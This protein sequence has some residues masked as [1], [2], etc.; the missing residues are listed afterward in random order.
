MKRT[1]WGGVFVAYILV[2]IIGYLLGCSNMATYVARAK[3][4]DIR[5]VGAG[6][7]GTANTVLVFGWGPGIIVGLHDIGKGVLATVIA[8]TLFP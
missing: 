7:P 5:T 8:K 1:Y 3:N 2:M 4:V 6:N